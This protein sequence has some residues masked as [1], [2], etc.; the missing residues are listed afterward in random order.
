M[1]NAATPRPGGP[2]PTGVDDTGQLSLLPAFDRAAIKPRFRLGRATCQ[3][4]LRHVA[5]IKEEL[6]RR[7]NERDVASVHRL[8]PRHRDAA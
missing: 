7:Q 8:P 6:A 5:E 1:K 2:A 3:R 4:G